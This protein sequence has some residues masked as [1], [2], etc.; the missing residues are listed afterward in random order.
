[1]RGQRYNDERSSRAIGGRNA[2]DGP[3]ERAQGPVGRE[4]L[5]ARRERGAP[6]PAPVTSAHDGRRSARVGAGSRRSPG[7]RPIRPGVAP[8]SLRPA[9]L[10]NPVPPIPLGSTPAGPTPM[11]AVPGSAVPGSAVPGSAVPRGTAPISRARRRSAVIAPSPM[12]SPSRHRA[13]CA[14][15]TTARG[16]RSRRKAPWSPPPAARLD[17]PA[18]RLLGGLTVLVLSAAVIIGWGVLLEVTAPAAAVQLA[19][20]GM[21]V[22][23]SGEP[24][25]GSPTAATMLVEVGSERTVWDLARRVRPGAD[26]P[27]LAAVAERIALLN[28]LP[29]VQ[30]RPGQ[31]LVVPLG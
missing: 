17:S 1:M 18:W 29:S 8:V 31:V 25:P 15:G 11:D 6:E 4:P 3:N 28:A 27:G 22:P 23:G 5:R 26:G 30:L 24:G 12:A 20:S 19:A 21:A 9:L 2:A 16:S 7:P 10:P 14:G 13:V